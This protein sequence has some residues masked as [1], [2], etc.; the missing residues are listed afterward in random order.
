MI[1]E[2][3]MIASWILIVLIAASSIVVY[4][5]SERGFRGVVS[6]FLGELIIMITIVACATATASYIFKSIQ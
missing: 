4:I 5:D 6:T 1:G 3:N 2:V